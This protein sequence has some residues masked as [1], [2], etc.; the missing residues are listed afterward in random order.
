M[1]V[2]RPNLIGVDV[3]GTFTDIVVRDERT[4]TMTVAKVPSTPADQSEGLMAGV[5]ELAVGP[6]TVSLL[7][8]G[9]TVAT[10]AV[11]ERKG[12]RCLLVTTRGFGDVLEL[13]RRDRLS[14]FGL[15][16]TGNPL[17][18]RDRRI[19]VDERMRPDGRVEVPLDADAL[20][21]AVEPHMDGIEAV[22]VAF[23]HSYANPAH[24]DRAVEVLNQRW[25]DH[26]VIASARSLPTVGE[27]ERTSTA[28][29][30][31]YVQ[32]MMA[33][34][35]GSLA[36]RVER[37]GYVRAPAVVQCNG[38]A[39]SLRHATERPANTVRSGP[40]AGVIAGTMIATAAGFPNAITGDM[41]G[42]SFDVALVVDGRPA[43]SD[44]IT[45]DF[46][47]PLRV[48]T[49]DV[50]TIGAGGGSL[51]SIDAAGILQVGP[52]SAGAVPGPACYG[53][54]GTRPTVTDADVVLGRISARRPI[55][56]GHLELDPELSARAIDEHV[57]SPLGISVEDAAEAIVHVIDSRMAGQV[58]MMSVGR[59]HDPREFVL[60]GFG[61]AGPLHTDAIIREVGIPRAIVPPLP[62]VTSAIGCLDADV[63]YDFLHS[64]RQ[65]L[66][67]IDMVEANKIVSEFLAEGRRLI[68]TG[69]VPVVGT[70]V[71]VE[72]EMQLEGQ[73]H[74]IRVALEEQL[75][76]SAMEQAF[77]EQYRQRYGTGL[78]APAFL[79]DLHCRVVGHRPTDVGSNTVPTAMSWDAAV[80]GAR[81][82]YFSG[83][84]QDAAI[85]ER[86][87]LTPGMTGHG[88]AIVQQDDTTTVIHPGTAVRVDGLRN[89][90]LEVTA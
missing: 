16:G 85:L 17:I 87:L 57:A 65:R 1:S 2:E 5:D 77:R 25:P 67:E 51:A 69:G 78:D 54:G 61:G 15:R 75:E 4:R 55:G 9:T 90:I 6:A 37:A 63:M 46:R 10:N 27:F 62:G 3:G 44:E 80:I 13:G 29:V 14:V 32:P 12:A 31:A 74:T 7:I 88:P 22:V 35:L 20:I 40:A 33:R 43:L 52:Q 81:P 82:A 34:Y 59:G 36:D 48:P 73:R 84:W 19:E 24:E 26:Y 30:H 83:Q 47:V 60:V 64:F 28:V 42:T 21:A 58:R 72:G 38:G 53:R 39:M 66:D 18:P 79:T 76:S 23:L 70:S 68:E 89:L 45:V 8:H 11:I 71:V 49:I 86:D 56:G 50:E 41:G